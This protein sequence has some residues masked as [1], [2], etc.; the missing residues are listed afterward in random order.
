M[1]YDRDDLMSRVIYSC[2]LF[3]DCVRSRLGDINLKEAPHSKQ[4]VRS[5]G[6][7]PEGG[8]PSN[9][10]PMHLEGHGVMNGVGGALVWSLTF[11]PAR[12]WDGLPPMTLVAPSFDL[13]ATACYFPQKGLDLFSFPGRVNEVKQGSKTTLSSL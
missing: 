3:V 10:P 9:G 11:H 7:Q 2:F 8:V 5:S 12:L 6:F 13:K 1:A 4:K